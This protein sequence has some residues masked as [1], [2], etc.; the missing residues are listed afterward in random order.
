[1]II[2]VS[3]V[4]TGL[5]LYQPHSIDGLNVRKPFWSNSNLK[6]RIVWK[7]KKNMKYN[8][9]W[10]TAESSN[11]PQVKLYEITKVTVSNSLLSF[12]IN[13]FININGPLSLG[14]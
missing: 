5:I 13:N 2:L 3:T 6:T 8:V 12:T 4:Q 7:A 11:L 10:W 14:T 1:M 9:T